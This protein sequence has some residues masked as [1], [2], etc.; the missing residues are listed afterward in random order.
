MLQTA[1][2]TVLVLTLM[3]MQLESAGQ[4]WPGVA[5]AERGNGFA[6]GR[7]VRL[8]QAAG[9]GDEIPPTGVVPASPEVPSLEPATLVYFAPQDNDANATVVVL[10]NTTAVTHTVNVKGFS[11][12][13]GVGVNVNVDVGPGGLVHVVSDSILNAP[14]SW[15]NS[16][17]ANFTDF[18]TY[19]SLAVPQGIKVDGYI[20]FNPG[21]G[22]IDPR[23]DQGAIPL[24]FSADPLTIFMP[25]VQRSP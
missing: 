25:A 7:S 5:L 17:I 8:P 1:I 18:T 19:A 24:R 13:G 20:I 23:S 15:T 16:V 2:I 6:G 3:G 11:S 4:W 12:G 22:T 21:T 9:A 10:Y 14:P